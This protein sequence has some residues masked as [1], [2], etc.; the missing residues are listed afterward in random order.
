MLLPGQGV[1]A[2]SENRQ[3]AKSHPIANTNHLKESLDHFQDMIE[4]VHIDLVS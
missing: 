3:N 1:K 2:E 4:F